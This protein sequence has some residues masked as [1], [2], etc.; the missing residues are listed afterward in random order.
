MYCCRLYSRARR[1]CTARGAHMVRLA[2]GIRRDRL[3]AWPR[4]SALDADMLLITLVGV[5]CRLLPPR[6][7]DHPDPLLELSHMELAQD[8]PHPHLGPAEDKP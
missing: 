6:T 5:C 2:F 8:A 1:M 7:D 4:T 3:P